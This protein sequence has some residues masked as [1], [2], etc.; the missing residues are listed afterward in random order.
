MFSKFL[1]YWVEHQD[2]ILELFIWKYVVIL[3]KYVF[4]KTNKIAHEAV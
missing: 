3:G 4:N 1:K 2:G